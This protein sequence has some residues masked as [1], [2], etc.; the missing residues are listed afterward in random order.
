MTPPTVA[1]LLSDG[2]T[3]A[4]EYRH[5]LETG[6]NI[7][8]TLDAVEVFERLVGFLE[9]AAHHADPEDAA[10]PADTGCQCVCHVYPEH[11]RLQDALD[12]LKWHQ[13]QLAARPAA[14]AVPPNGGLTVEELIGAIHGGTASH[15]ADVVSC[16]LWPCSMI[17]IPHRFSTDTSGRN[18]NDPGEC[19]L[20]CELE[21]HANHQL[22]PVVAEAAAPRPIA[23]DTVKPGHG[24]DALDWITRAKRAEQQIA[25]LT[26]ERDAWKLLHD[27]RVK[28][29]APGGWIDNLRQSRSPQAYQDLLDRMAREIARSIDEKKAAESSLAALQAALEQL[30]RYSIVGPGRGEMVRWTDLHGVLRTATQAPI[31]DDLHIELAHQANAL[32]EEKNRPR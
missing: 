14:S 12:A 6:R 20:C 27:D 9:A 26:A 15:G 13:E 2:K 21:A 19:Y 32:A 5:A 8:A 3:M 31:V 4:R 10:R 1:A 30:P 23:Q 16:A 28:E 7:V 24:G 25:T 22:P 18:W 17:G 11:G 29:N